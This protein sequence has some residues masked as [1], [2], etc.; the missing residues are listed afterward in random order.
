MANSRKPEQNSELGPDRFRGLGAF[1]LY[2]KDSSVSRHPVWVSLLC[3]LL[4][5][6]ILTLISISAGVTPRGFS[7]L[8]PGYAAVLYNAFGATACAAI[9][10]SIFRQSRF[11]PIKKLVGALLMEQYATVV[12][13][14][15]IAVYAI[16]S[17]VLAAGVPYVLVFLDI[18]LIGKW[19]ELR[20][21]L[22]SLKVDLAVAARLNEAAAERN[23][24]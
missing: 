2:T 7:S 9:L 1:M 22:R 23:G 6:Q 20:R 11:I 14:L 16:H 5:G 17:I 10:I 4:L 12:L 19:F 21:E 15:V 18:G 13:F 24:H 8:I 3:G